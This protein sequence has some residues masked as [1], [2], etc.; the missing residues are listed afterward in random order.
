MPNAVEQ[1]KNHFKQ[2]Q[3]KYD[4]SNKQF[5]LTTM[6]PMNGTKWLT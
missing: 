3:P 4:P 1:I 6:A 2:T 5:K